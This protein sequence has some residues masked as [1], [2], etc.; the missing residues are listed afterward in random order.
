MEKKRD[1]NKDALFAD[2]RFTMGIVSATEVT[3]MVPTPPLDEDEADGYGD[4]FPVR[5]ER[6]SAA[7]RADSPDEQEKR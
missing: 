3:G 2:D 5:Q 6:A 1:Q 4:L 7:Q